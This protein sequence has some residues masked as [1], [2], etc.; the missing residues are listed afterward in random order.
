MYEGHLSGRQVEAAHNGQLKDA[1]DGFNKAPLTDVI[2]DWD[3]Q[4]FPL[5]PSGNLT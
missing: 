2:G 3:E 4:F 5:V 1:L